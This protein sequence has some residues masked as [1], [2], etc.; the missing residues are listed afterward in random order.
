MKEEEVVKQLK[1]NTE[2]ISKIYDTLDAIQKQYAQPA[3]P[4]EQAKPASND[5]LSALLN[6]NNLPPELENLKKTVARSLE[7][8]MM[9]TAS[10]SGR[11][12]NR[13]IYGARS[14]VRAIEQLVRT[15]VNI[16]DNLS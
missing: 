7:V 2:M 15:S 3:Q 5:V 8:I 9:Q 4:V 16:F 14:K 11:G 12:Q 6:S 10:A 1:S 13:D